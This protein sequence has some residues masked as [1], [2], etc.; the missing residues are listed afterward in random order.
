MDTI[1]VGKIESGCCH[2]G[3]KCIIMPN[4]KLVEI[5]NI[6]YDDTETD[7]CLYG[8]NVRLKLKNV[9][10][11]VSLVFFINYYFLMRIFRK[12]YLDLFYAMF[13]MYHVELDESL[14]HK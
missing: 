14:M 12:S 13:N 2:V 7:F 1:I 6:Y 10:K 3:D 9:K 11:N 8:T 5:T 4:R